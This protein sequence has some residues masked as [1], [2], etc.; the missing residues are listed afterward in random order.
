LIAANTKQKTKQNKPKQKTT[1]EAEHMV[2]N[3]LNDLK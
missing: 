3:L 1:T 2:A